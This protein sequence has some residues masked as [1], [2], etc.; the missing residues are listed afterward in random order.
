MDPHMV[1]W[2]DSLYNT[3]RQFD[4]EVIAMARSIRFIL[5][6][7]LAVVIGGMLLVA[8]SWLLYYGIYMFFETVFFPTD[9]Q[10][11]P[12]DQIRTGSAVVLFL[13]YLVVS[14]LRMPAV[15][16]ATLFVA[17]LTMMLITIVLDL[18]MRPLAA[19]AVFAALV[20][21][22]IFIVVRFRRHWLFGLAIAMSVV[23]SLLYAWPR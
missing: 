1:K 19:A 2:A 23:V 20:A 3:Y 21:G 6:P 16:K 22:S 8:L 11:V 12:A 9:P 13:F 17:P 5:L 10:S 18:Y 15:V 7:A 14:R 4:P